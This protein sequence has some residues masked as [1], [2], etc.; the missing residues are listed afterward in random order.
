MKNRIVFLL[1][2]AP[3]YREFILKK[4]DQEL[5]ADLYFGNIP[6]S[7]IKKLDYNELRNFKKELKTL[8][9][10]NIYWYIGSLQIIFKPYKKIILTGDPQILSNWVILIFARLLG[11]RTFLWTHGWYGDEKGIK[12]IIKKI[13][14]GLANNILLYGDYAKGLMIKDGFKENKLIPIY[15]SLNYEQQL[16][17]RKVQQKT[18]IYRDHFKN[19]NPVLIYIGRIQKIKRLDLI[20]SAMKLLNEKGICL[21]LVVIGGESKDYDIRA[22]IKKYNL[23]NQ[24]WLYGSSYNEE[25]NGTLIYNADL[26]VSP[27]NVGL[28]AIHSLMYGTPVITHNNFSKQMPE[29]ETIIENYTGIFFEENNVNDLVQKIKIILNLKIERENCYRIIEEKWNPHNQI[30]ILKKVLNESAN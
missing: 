5:N 12:K 1:N 9:L 25:T 24:V 10:K 3:H 30:N 29:F 16:Q 17:I 19:D 7:S 4:I 6:N 28:T 22:D 20:I 2:F 18:S 27:G 23:E 13:Y 21:N 14:F 26:C 15:N 11:K 8:K